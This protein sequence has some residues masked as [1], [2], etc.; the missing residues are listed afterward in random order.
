M[1]SLY[2]QITFFCTLVF[3]MHMCFCIIQKSSGVLLS[4]DWLNFGKHLMT[5]PGLNI[6]R[7]DLWSLTYASER[8]LLLLTYRKK[9]ALLVQ[10]IL[11]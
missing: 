2:T 8:S 1:A 9:V 4:V 7:L 6:E 11:K 3:N 10:E 5:K